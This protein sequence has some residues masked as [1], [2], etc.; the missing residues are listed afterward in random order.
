MNDAN[1]Q[2]GFVIPVT[3]ESFILG[4][5]GQERLVPFQFSKLVVGRQ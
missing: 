4:G 3:G 1:N 5:S 2:K